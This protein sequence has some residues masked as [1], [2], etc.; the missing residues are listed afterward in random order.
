[1]YSHQHITEVFIALLAKIESEG[2]LSKSEQN[3]FNRYANEYYTFYADGAEG[4][5][6]E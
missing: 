4:R 5:D 6:I 3:I 2:K 1:M